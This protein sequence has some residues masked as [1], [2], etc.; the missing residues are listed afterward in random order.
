MSKNICPR[1]KGESIIVD[2]PV[3][4]TQ[5]LCAGCEIEIYAE[6]RTVMDRY[7]LDK[8]SAYEYLKTNKFYC[9]VKQESEQ[10]EECQE[11][12]QNAVDKY[13]RMTQ[14]DRIRSMSDEELAE[15]LTNMCDF[16]NQ[17]D[18]EPYKSIYNI[19]T[20]KEET[21]HDSYGSI[22]EWLQSKVE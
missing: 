1:C 4:A 17:E 6:L 12:K 16:I 18:E 9:D 11:C 8:E 22:M 19:D 3:D 5:C 2:N 7:G 14:A 20:G 10:Y 15:W 21:V 13:T